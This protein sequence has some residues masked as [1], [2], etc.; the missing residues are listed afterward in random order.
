MNSL[1]HIGMPKSASTSLQKTFFTYGE[2]FY[3][4]GR[5]GVGGDDCISEAVRS[6]LWEDIFLDDFGYKKREALYFEDIKTHLQHGLSQGKIPV[7]SQEAFSMPTLFSSDY[8]VIFSRLSKIFDEPVIML[9]VRNQKS[10]LQSFY[11]TLVTDM[12][13]S[14]SFENFMKINMEFPAHKLNISRCLDYLHIVDKLKKYFPKVMLVVFEEFIKNPK[15]VMTKAFEGF[16]VDLDLQNWEIGTANARRDI[17]V[18]RHARSLNEKFPR[19]VGLSQDSLSLSFNSSE[20]LAVQAKVLQKEQISYPDA[21]VYYQVIGDRLQQALTMHKK[22][23]LIN[24]AN[25][26]KIIPR[27]REE[28]IVDEAWLSALYGA[29]NHEFSGQ[30]GLELQRYD[31]AIS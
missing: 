15:S 29:S 3:P 23:Q 17:D 4:L 13:S 27:S 9:F 24:I 31:Y 30:Y 18:I 8:E 7:L 6:L 26:L 21:Q 16:G 22:D 28:F 11:S 20:F 10:I 12:G 19:G 1:I 2:Y 14:L 25:T 5:F